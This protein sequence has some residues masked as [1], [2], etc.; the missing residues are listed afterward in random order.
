MLN[1]NKPECQVINDSVSSRS[2]WAERMSA[3]HKPARC[4]EHNQFHNWMLM[5]T[6]EKR[7]YAGRKY[8]TRFDAY[9]EIA[10]GKWLLR[11]VKTKKKS[12]D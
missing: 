11:D 3:T 6:E 8:G 10:P 5:T 12:D 1:P 2:M 4:T 9:V 7:D